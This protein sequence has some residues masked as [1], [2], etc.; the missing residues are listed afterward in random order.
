[1]IPNKIMKV[2][3]AMFLFSFMFF[4]EIDSSNLNNYMLCQ[5]SIFD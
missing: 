2:N 3:I 4:A 1:M 5:N